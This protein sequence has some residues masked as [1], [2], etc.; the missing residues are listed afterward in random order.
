VTMVM[1]LLAAI[2]GVFSW[3]MRRVGARLADGV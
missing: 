3:L 2:I 1:V